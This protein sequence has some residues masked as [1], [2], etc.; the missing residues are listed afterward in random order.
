MDMGQNWHCLRAPSPRVAATP[1]IPIDLPTRERRGVA[2]REVPHARYILEPIGG[3]TTRPHL[4]WVFQV[5]STII[6]DHNDI[7][8]S[9]A[10]SL[11]LA[12][13]QVSGAVASV[14]EDWGSSFEPESLENC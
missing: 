14:A 12:L 7:F 1:Y 6:K 2:D 4:T 10:L 9:R 3:T 5:P 8:N 13:I 11:T